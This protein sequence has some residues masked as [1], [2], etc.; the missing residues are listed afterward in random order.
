MWVLTPDARCGRPF[1]RL[2]VYVC[3][4]VCALRTRVCVVNEH[5]RKKSELTQPCVHVRVYARA[6]VCACVCLC[7]CV[8][9]CV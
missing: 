1:T 8:R 6:Y 3:V 7:L 5:T 2:C 4:Y 9:A